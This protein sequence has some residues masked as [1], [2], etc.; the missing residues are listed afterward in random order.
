MDP[1]KNRCNGGGSEIKVA[2]CID[3]ILRMG[4][5]EVGCTPDRGSLAFFPSIAAIVRRRVH[6]IHLR[7]IFMLALGVLYDAKTVDPKIAFP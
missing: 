7:Y 1:V 3:S 5:L 2:F 6:N 4:S